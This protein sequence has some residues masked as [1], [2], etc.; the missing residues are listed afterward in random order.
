MRRRALIFDDQADSRRQMW[1]ILNRRD[2]EVFSYL[3]PGVCPLNAVQQYPCPEE[4]IC[5]DLIISDI[6]MLRANG[7]DFVQQLIE[8]KC[9]LP[10]LAV[11]S[12]SWT[13]PDRRRAK[14][15]G[16]KV[17]EKPLAILKLIEWL[18]EIEDSIP[19]GR[20]LFDLLASSGLH[21]NPFLVPERPFLQ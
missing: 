9:R 7:I 15:F 12:E 10:H 1:A 11:I 19:P 8:K 16:C 17:F 14:E 4:A 6:Q 3:N 21:A 18:D 20:R 13:E 2:Y 5:A